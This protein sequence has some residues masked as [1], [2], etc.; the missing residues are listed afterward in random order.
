MNNRDTI[1]QLEDDRK[2]LIDLIKKAQ[3]YIWA[4]GSNHERAACEWQDEALLLLKEFEV[5]AEG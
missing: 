5:R 4:T 2:R 1:K 3:P